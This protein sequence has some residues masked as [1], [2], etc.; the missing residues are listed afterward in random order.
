MITGKDCHYKFFWTGDS[1]GLGG[2]G[3]LITENLAD[4]V[5]SVTRTNH[6]HMNI[7]IL[8]KDKIIHL[9]SVYAPQTGRPQ[10]EKD[11]FYNILL[12]N[13]STVATSEHLVVGGEFSGH[14]GR[15]CSRLPCICMFV[16][17]FS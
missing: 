5:L 8:I 14:V 13:I 2:V 9:L 1:S 11:S 3:F 15:T 4:K 6:R 10:E 12:D 16:G 7:R 17:L